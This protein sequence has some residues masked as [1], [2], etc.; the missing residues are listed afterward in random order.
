[1]K[2]YYWIKLAG[3]ASCATPAKRTGEQRLMLIERELRKQGIAFVEDFDTNG[4]VVLR[5][6]A[7]CDDTLFDREVG[8]AQGNTMGEQQAICDAILLIGRHRYY[9]H[10][11]PDSGEA[12]NVRAQVRLLERLNDLNPRYNGLQDVY[13]TCTGRGDALEEAVYA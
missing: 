12:W 5:Y 4:S 6:G 1:M 3:I 2:G 8:N 7:Y 13:D 10:V 9:G 11:I